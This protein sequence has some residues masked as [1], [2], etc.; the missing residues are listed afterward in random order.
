[1]GIFNTTKVNKAAIS[2]QPKVEA[3]AVGGSFYSSQVAGPNLIGDWWSYQAGL[4]RNR[5][6]S[7][8]AISR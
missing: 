7:V 5:A 2:P 3:A 8:A 4:L 1:M 6:M